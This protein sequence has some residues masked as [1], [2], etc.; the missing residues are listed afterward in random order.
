[1]HLT[2]DNITNFWKKVTKTD[3]CWNW[4]AAIYRASGY[5]RMHTCNKVQAAHRISWFL[6]V[7]VIPENMFVLHKCDNRICVN[8]DHLWLG[9]KQDNYDDMKAKGRERKALGS[10]SGNSKLNE[11]D[12]LEIRRLYSVG[13]RACDIAIKFNMTKTT[14]GQIVKRQTWRHI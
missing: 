5:G 6:N 1:M 9:T 11:R 4:N 3:Y 14:I 8:P 13:M 2:G 12:V 10:N 7:G